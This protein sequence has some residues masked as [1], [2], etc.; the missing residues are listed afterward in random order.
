MGD[1]GC[2][3]AKGPFRAAARMVK[4]RWESYCVRPCTESGPTP[5]CKDTGR[6]VSLAVVWGLALQMVRGLN[7]LERCWARTEA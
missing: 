1:S 3:G 5:N 6:G 7:G 2:L 4:P